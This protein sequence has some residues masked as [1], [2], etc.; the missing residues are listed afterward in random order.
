MPRRYASLQYVLKD[1]QTKGP[2]YRRLKYDDKDD[3]AINII[4]DDIQ[5]QISHIRLGPDTYY[6]S[7]NPEVS[8]IF[9]T[10]HPIRFSI[11]TAQEWE[12]QEKLM[13]LAEQTGR[14][15]EALPVTDSQEHSSLETNKTV[16]LAI[17]KV[18]DTHLGTNL[19]AVDASEAD[20]H[21]PGETPAQI[22]FMASK[23]ATV[24]SFPVG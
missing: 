23:P 21:I 6:V 18:R 15:I 19:D 14:A 17:S 8:R 3:E 24:A 2:L 22:T 11:P 10:K 5:D 13:K 7:K 16:K 12:I 1:L 9:N 20:T 4:I